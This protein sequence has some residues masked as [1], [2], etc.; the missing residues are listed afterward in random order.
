M[1]HGLG[2]T[3]SGPPRVG[4]ACHT[5][6]VA[7]EN[8]YRIQ[9]LE[10]NTG[11]HVRFFGT[12]THGA[13]ADQLQSPYDVALHEPAPGSD[14]PTL[15]FV[16]D[17]GKHRVQVFNADTGALVRTIGTTG[18]AGDAMGQ[19]NR[20]SGVAVHPGAEGAMLLFV[21]ENGNNRV[22]VFAL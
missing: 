10:A 4:P 19:L 21:T 20:P 8:S 13:A 17:Y 2:S 6:H 5:I 7:E 1:S 22:Q 15:L 14:Q 18:Q 12:G 9:A 16:A 11:T 3:V